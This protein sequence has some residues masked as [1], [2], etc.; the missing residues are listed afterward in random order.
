VTGPEPPGGQQ[1]PAWNS[2]PDLHPGICRCCGQQM[3]LF[4]WMTCAEFDRYCGHWWPLFE[5]KK[6]G[7]PIGSQYNRLGWLAAKYARDFTVAE[8]AD[9]LW[10]AIEASEQDHGYGRNGRWTRREIGYIAIRAR[11]SIE[12][13]DAAQARRDAAFMAY[14]HASGF[15]R[16]AEATL[17]DAPSQTRQPGS[18]QPGARRAGARP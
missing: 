7:I 5:A 12:H 15:F 13:S 4:S 2:Q 1:Q 6:N 3:A 11:R 18:R 17:A 16:W 9:E 14:L 8:L 10:E